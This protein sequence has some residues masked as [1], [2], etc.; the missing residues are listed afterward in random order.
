MKLLAKT[1]AGLEETLASEIAQLGGQNSQIIK[2]GVEFEGDTRLMY[3]ANLELRT[4]LRI[5][6]PVATFRAR[7]D[8]VLYAKL[9][10]IDFQAFMDVKQ[11]FAVDAVVRSN[12]F[13]HSQYVALKTKDAIADQFREKLNKRPNVNPLN[14][15][16]LFNIHI[17]EEDVTLSLDASGDSLHKRGYHI[18]AVEAPI[19][20]VLAAG[21]IQLSNWDG[22]KTF[23]DAMC[24]SGTLL[25]E[26]AMKAHGIPPQY[27]RDYFCFKRWRNFDAALFA[28]IV[29]TQKAQRIDYQN[30][31]AGSDLSFQAMRIAERNIEAA[32]LKGKIAV[33]RKDFFKFSPENLANTEGVF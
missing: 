5:L 14:P 3:R 8:T 9:K 11:T 23:Y 18:D 28:D 25:T 20:E 19:N 26:A 30:I 13:T 22:K 21:M 4:A 1:L 16:V 24:G 17:N 27:G 29:A 32:D 15:D 7:H 31:I 10:N 33:S 12:Y 6:I 2:R